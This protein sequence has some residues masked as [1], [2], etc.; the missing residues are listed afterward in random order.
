[1]FSVRVKKD[2]KHGELESHLG[3]TYDFEN[4]C[5][6]A[7]FFVALLEMFKV[8]EF[9]IEISGKKGHE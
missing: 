9:T 2:D 7:K 8:G 5:E 3:N 4:A 1:M 6:K